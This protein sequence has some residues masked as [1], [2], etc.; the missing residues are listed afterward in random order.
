M[1]GGKGRQGRERKASICEKYMSSVANMFKFAANRRSGRDHAHNREE[2]QPAP[3][4][5]RFFSR[6][7]YY[8]EDNRGEPDIDQKATEF[9]T[10][11]HRNRSSDADRQSVVV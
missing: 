4:Q 7:Y 3:P 8:E 2:V 6:P 10:N 9:I 1:G 11:F 5:S